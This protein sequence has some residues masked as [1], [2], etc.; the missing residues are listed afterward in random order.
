M[1]SSHLGGKVTGLQANL[2][3]PQDVETLIDSI[4]SHGAISYL[5]NAA[6]YF[7]PKA[8]ID[9]SM[10]DY[11]TYMELNKATFRISQAVATEYDS[12]M[13]AAVS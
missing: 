4:N 8:F 11:D 6:G 12:I 7:N 9:H 2:Y 1:S 5:V 10:A 3:Q 13:V